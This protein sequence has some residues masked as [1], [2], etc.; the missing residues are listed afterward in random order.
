MIQSVRDTVVI[1]LFHLFRAVR[2][3]TIL[4]LFTVYLL[5]SGGTA[6]MGR[7]IIHEFEKQ[8]ADTLMVP[9]TK[10]PGAMMETLRTQESFHRLLKGMIP[11]VELLEWALTLPILTIFHY[12]I[13]LFAL[14]FIVVVIG[15]ESISPSIQDR[16]LRYELLRTGRLEIVMGRLLG[17]SFLIGAGTI[18]AC[19]GP[20]LV[21]SFFMT[22]QPFWTT[23]WVLLSF[24]PKL[25]VW[26]VPFLGFGI[27]LS[28]L[29]QMTNAARIFAL[30]AVAA[31]WILYAISISPY[32]QEKYTLFFDIVSPL[33]P[34]SYGT[35]LWLPSWDWMLSG[36]ILFSMGIVYSLIGYPLFAR[37]NI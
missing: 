29:T 4:F 25:F 23:V 32:F 6:W 31:S 2:T 14:P 7:S 15:A 10:T 35:A 5:I 37:R 18:L 12:W 22:A 21:G 26:S 34:Q 1:A 16:S 30:G 9:Q 24:I 33:L 28:M 8:A 11:D 36:C 19:L 13:S 17:Q 3:R 27:T 20:L